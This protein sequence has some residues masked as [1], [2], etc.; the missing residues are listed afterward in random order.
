MN[1]DPSH[2]AY[3]DPLHK[4]N[5]LEYRSG[6]LCIEKG[7]EETAGT[8]WSPHWCFKHNVERMD[9]ISASLEGIAASYEKATA[10][11]RHGYE[12][13]LAGEPSPGTDN[14]DL[15]RG[16]HIGKEERSKHALSDNGAGQ[17]DA[18]QD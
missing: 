7:C 1:D 3:R 6:K 11:A 16:W 14:W 4:G 5:G 18:A 12:M 8:W 17:A 13:G 15:W 9:R 10:D 2:K